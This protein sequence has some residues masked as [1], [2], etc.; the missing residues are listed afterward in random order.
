MRR[1]VLKRAASICMREFDFLRTEFGY[2]EPEVTIVGQSGFYVRYL[3]PVTGVEVGWLLGIDEGLYV[4]I[5]RLRDGRFPPEEEARPDK[6]IDIFDLESLEDFLGFER[7]LDDEALARLPDE[8][9]A[10]AMARSLRVCGEALLRGD[11]SLLGPLETWCK[12]SLRAD[13]VR[14]YGEEGA[15]RFGW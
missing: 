8:Q 11:L 3:G 10:G 12:E 2:S 15:R 14:F 1:D 4:E 5:A 9:T 13:L 6:P 7:E